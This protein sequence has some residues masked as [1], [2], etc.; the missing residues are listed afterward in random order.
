MAGNDFVMVQLSVDGAAL[1]KGSSIRVSN[2]RRS[3]SFTA[4][5]AQR[6]ERS[7]E[8]LAVLSRQVAPD[9]KKLFELAPAP[10]DAPVSQPVEAP[11]IPA[12]PAPAVPAAATE[13]KK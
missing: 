12:A 5:V 13:E 4:G 10:A 7:Y 6:V 3:F 2:G 8:W 1:A 9:G 11:V